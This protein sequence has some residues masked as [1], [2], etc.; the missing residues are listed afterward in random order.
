MYVEAM[1][2]LGMVMRARGA[3]R[4]AEALWLRA[5]KLRPD[6]WDAIDHLLHALCE[7]HTLPN[8]SVQSP[9][10]NEAL[11]VL[12]YILNVSLRADGLLLVF[13]PPA[14]LHRLQNL[15]HTSGNIRSMNKVDPWAGFHDYIRAIEL[16]FRPPGSVESGTP[17]QL[18]DVVVATT[19][20]GLL[21][22]VS[23]DS[24]LPRKIA[25]ALGV[26]TSAFN[27]RVLE[28][29]IDWLALVQQANSR[30]LDI[31]LQEGDG[32][33]PVVLLAPEN[34][35]RIPSALF[36]AFSHSLPALCTREPFEDLWRLAPGVGDAHAKRTTAMALLALA[37]LFQSSPQNRH[38]F[39][40]S[41]GKRIPR[42]TSL[43]IVFY[44]LALSLHPTA[45]TYNNLG[46]IFDSVKHSLPALSR[47]GRQ[48]ILTGT[49]LA[50]LYYKKGLSVDP[51]HPHLLTNYGSLLK[52]QGRMLEAIGLYQKALQS[53]PNFDIALANLANVIQD[54]GAIP[55]SIAY[56]KR[57]LEVAPG[58]PDAICG[59]SSA[60]SSI[61][62]WRWGRGSIGNEPLVDAQFRFNLR[63]SKEDQTPKGW[64]G[65]MEI[66]SR[67]QLAA[68]YAIGTGIV[69]ALG[70][71]E[72][73]IQVVNN[74]TNF[75]LD[76]S[77]QRSQKAVNEV[78]FII[79][80]IESMNQIVQRRWYRD[81]YLNPSERSIT[82]LEAANKVS[83]KRARLPGPLGA[84]IVPALLPFHCFTYALDNR[85]YRLIAHR[86]A[87]RISYLAL[88]APWHP[89]TVYKPPPPPFQKLNVG[90]VSSDF[91][92]HP[93]AH[94]MLSVFGLHNRSR[95]NIFAYATSASDNSQYRRKIEED[96]DCFYDL[97]ASSTE[98]IVK[99][100]VSDQ[101]HILINLG[102]YTR[103]TRN[104][105]FA[106]RPC[107]VQVSL[108]GYAGTSG[109]GW[110]DYLVGDEHACPRKAFGPFKAAEERRMA[111]IAAGVQGNSNVE[112]DVP[113]SQIDPDSE[114]T[115]WAL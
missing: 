36:S 42:S 27:Q 6:Y 38:G 62:D 105:I 59:L 91:N 98:S 17:L 115:D 86:N 40:S 14:R 46:I 88:K 39:L 94:L 31:L 96:V 99:Q 16:M 48:Q 82:G 100:I 3:N 19:V 21:T 34:V 23:S 77:Q 83:Y 60:L 20:I 30:L 102:G 28:R 114:A 15:L 87:L 92:N 68:A 104:D 43:T 90:Y 95:F 78:A 45:S 50:E 108:M 10:Y 5:I 70:T 111:G 35:L 103:G 32:A 53:R 13:I 61:C 9:R 110:C 49:T 81:L 106:A 67:K 24:P 74:A 12:D 79:H 11:A 73:W 113:I 47:H 54:S 44:Y 75:E 107:P 56:Y 8:G 57:A 4:E 64:M 109:A 18:S 55:K 1:S 93:L 71:V 76:G 101:I 41:R 25:S 33:L 72:D 84:P 29:G 97:S 26:E 85:T 52:D 51:K 22:N 37:R 58:F 65:E 80:L 63:P 2:N 89:Q 112:W 7:N 66:A 69:R